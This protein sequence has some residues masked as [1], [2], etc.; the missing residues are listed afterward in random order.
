[1]IKHAD[2]SVMV[3]AALERICCRRRYARRSHRTVFSLGCDQ[4]GQYRMIRSSKSVDWTPSSF[5][6]T[7][8]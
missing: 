1:M 3:T 7:Y 4:C 6:A 8:E 2:G 5:F